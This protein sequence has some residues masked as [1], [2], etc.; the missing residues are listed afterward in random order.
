MN[1]LGTNFRL[2]NKKLSLTVP[3]F[4]L[5]LA[6]LL[7]ACGGQEPASPTESPSESEVTDSTAPDT[8]EETDAGSESPAESESRR[9]R[10]RCLE[11]RH[12]TPGHHRPCFHLFR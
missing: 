9:S 10:G 8:E 12:A 3:I 6:L 5:I 11:G 2:H 4:L 1:L 7:V